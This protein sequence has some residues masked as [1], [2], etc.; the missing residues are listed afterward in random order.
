MRGQ[1]ALALPQVTTPTQA[2]QTILRAGIDG[3]AQS[4]GDVSATLLGQDISFAS[5]AEKTAV[6]GFA[7]ADV[8]AAVGHSMMLDSGFELGYGSDNAF[9]ARGQIRLSKSF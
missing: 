7:G 9:T 4:S 8:A 3:I 6:R 2:W 5:G 1:L